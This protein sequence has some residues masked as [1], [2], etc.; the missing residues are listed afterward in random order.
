MAIGPEG[1]SG[2]RQV[3]KQE[4]ATLCHG[5]ELRVC[6]WTG[7]CGWRRQTGREGEIDTEQNIS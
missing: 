3:A 2:G 7:E 5:R 1:G 6:G 4:R